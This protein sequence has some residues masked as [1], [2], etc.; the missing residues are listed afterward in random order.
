MSSSG[1]RVARFRQKQRDSGRRLVTMYLHP[2]IIAKLRELSK[3]RPMGEVVEQAIAA[4]CAT[5]T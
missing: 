3:R 4:W 1:E 5:N 2:K